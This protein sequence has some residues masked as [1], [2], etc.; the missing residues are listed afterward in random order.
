MVNLVVAQFG[1]ALKTYHLWNLCVGMHV[2]EA[3]H[4]LRHR[5]KQT[6]VGVAHG[7]IQVFLILRNGI[8]IGKHFIHTSMLVAQHALHLFVVELCC[9]EDSPVTEFQEERFRLFI[10]AI[11]P[12]ITQSCIH[13]VE[14]VE[15]CPST[16]INSEVATLHTLPDVFAVWHTT[17]IAQTPIGMVLQ[18]CLGALSHFT[19]DVFHAFSAFLITRCSIDSH[20]REVVSTHVSVQSVPVG[21]AFG[22]Q[23]QSSFLAI[24]CHQ[25]VAIVLQKCLDVEVTSMLERTI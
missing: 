2:V 7:C 10:A 18:V 19:D 4:A 11:K 21:I 22:F 25:S 1:N 13:L 14:V 16:A 3:I 5:E 15:R 12:C 23:F 8:G 9:D 17:H 6:L 24:G 20:R